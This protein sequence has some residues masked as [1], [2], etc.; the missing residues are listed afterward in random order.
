MKDQER[1]SGLTRT[2]GDLEV[3]RRIREAIVSGTFLPNQRLVEADL[4]KLFGANR[5]KIRIALARLVQEGLVVNEP[6]RGARVRLVSDTEAL[7]ISEARGALEALMARGAAIRATDADR[8][9]LK[10]IVVELQAAFDAGDLLK[11]SAINKRLHNAIYDIAANK[12][13]LRLIEALQL[14]L[15]RFQYRI[16]L[17]P[18]RGAKALAEHKRIVEAICTGDPDIAEDAV[19]YHAKQVMIALAEAIRLTKEHLPEETREPAQSHA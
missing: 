2:R 12:T 11:C 9:R 14:Q 13:V 6:N 4:A 10:A 8:E 3:T 15:I 19:R 18:G 17:V 7:E 1:I 5:G 16:I